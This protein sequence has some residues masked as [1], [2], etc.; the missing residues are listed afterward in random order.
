MRGA[1]ISLLLAACAPA[2]PSRSRGAIIGGTR[3]TGDPAVMLLVS[4]P[5][6]QSTLYTCTASLIA[7]SLL[8]TAAHCVDDAHHA[9]QIFGVF[10]GDDASSYTLAALAP[11]LV[12]VAA[13]H[14]HPSYSSSPPFVA[15]IAVVELGRALA[16][17]PLP[18]ARVLQPAAGDPARLVGYGQ[19]QYGVYNASKYDAETVIA[20]VPGD[21]TIVVGDAQRRSC[22][23]DSGGPVL[24]PTA[25]GE[26]IAGVDSYTDTSGCTQPSHY[27]RVDA[28][29]D[30]LDGY[31]PPPPDAAT[32]VDADATAHDGA[33]RDAASHD[34]S[35]AP[36]SDAATDASDGAAARAGGRV[37]TGS[38]GGCSVGGAPWRGGL[39]PLMLLLVVLLRRNGRRRQGCGGTWSWIV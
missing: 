9:G 31:L 37:A 18:L 11:L 1:V 29:L 4:Y 10:T 30:F 17:E 2:P 27:R 7:P 8:V 23:G 33:T 12:P 32:P 3:D 5:P 36:A 13:V 26:A 14:A 38:S 28:Y 6:N 34:G 16:T 21:D 24:V 35:R 15:D 20:S 19:T 25:S 22:V 39:A